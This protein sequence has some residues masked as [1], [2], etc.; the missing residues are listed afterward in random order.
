MALFVNFLL[1]TFL[2]KPKRSRFDTVEDIQKVSGMVINSL[3]VKDFQGNVP[4]MEE[5]L[6]SA[7]ACV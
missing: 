1:T 2:M 6:K 5:A 3:A 4:V 7:I